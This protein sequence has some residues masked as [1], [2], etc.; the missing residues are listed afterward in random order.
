MANK[1]EFDCKAYYRLINNILF[2]VKPCADHFF[3]KEI[4][5]NRPPLYTGCFNWSQCMLSGLEK[6]HCIFLIRV[7]YGHIMLDIYLIKTICYNFQCILYI[8]IYCA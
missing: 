3:T 2:F 8:E 5:Q 7:L 1:N 4:S 6:F